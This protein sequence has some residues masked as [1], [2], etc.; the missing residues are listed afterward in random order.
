MVSEVDDKAALKWNNKLEAGDCEVQDEKP[1]VFI[2]PWKKAAMD[3]E[4]K[5]SSALAK[6]GKLLNT[7]TTTCIK[8]D[9]QAKAA[10]LNQQVPAGQTLPGVTKKNLEEKE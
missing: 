2:E 8:L 5:I 9:A 7:A 10:P 6:A 4:R 1:I 3:V